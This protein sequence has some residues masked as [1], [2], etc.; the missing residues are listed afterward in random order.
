M[1]K[2]ICTG[3]GEEHEVTTRKEFLNKHKLELLQ[4][5]ARHVSNQMDNNFGLK[6]VFGD[7][8][9]N[10]NNFQKLRYHGLVHHVRH[11]GALVRGRWLIT[12]NGWAFLRG[13]LSLP[14]WVMVRGNRVLEMRALDKLSVTEVYVGSE[15]IDTVFEYFDEFNNPVGWRPTAKDRNVRLFA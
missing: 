5:A 1:S 7:N 9:N 13:D 15:I 6:E 8:T 4:Q 10:Y 2:H 12:R 11:N 3:C 14:K